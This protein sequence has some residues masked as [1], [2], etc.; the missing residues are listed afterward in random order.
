VLLISTAFAQFDHTFEPNGAGGLNAGAT[1]KHDFNPNLSGT[2]FGGATL[3]PGN[4]FNQVVTNP[5]V[6]GAVEYNK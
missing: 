1:Y 6:G 3:Y 5:H 2:A 4:K